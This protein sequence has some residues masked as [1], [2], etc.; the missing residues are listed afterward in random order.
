M[1]KGDF[2]VISEFLQEYIFI[3][4]LHNEKISLNIL[5]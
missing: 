5:G 1:A 4:Q 2:S 3:Y